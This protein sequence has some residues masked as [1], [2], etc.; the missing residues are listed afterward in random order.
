M[1]RKFISD[2]R[3]NMTVSGFFMV[4]SKDIRIAKNNNPYL[5]ITLM[6]KTGTIQA[7]IWDNVETFSE[8]FEKGDPVAVK[9]TITSFNNELQLKISSIRRVVPAQDKAYGYTLDDLIPS[10]QKDIGQM[11]QAIMDSIDRITN[12]FLQKLLRI[13]YTEHESILKTHPA[14][15]IL[16]HAF[17]GGLLEHT[18][19]MLNVAIG[20]CNTYPELD[21]ELVIS[22]VLLH[23]IG[24]IRELDSGLATDY[25]DCGNFIG[26]I[27]LGRDILLETIAKIDDFPEMLKLKLEHIILSHQGKLEWQ[28]PKE[29]SF[30]EALIVYFIDEMDTRLNQMT[31]EL[32]NDNAEGNWT[33][34]NNYFRRPLFK[35]SDS[36]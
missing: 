4:F 12:P 7:K 8:K 31:R 22:G 16:H 26:H 6:D 1:E 17:R 28:S 9:G 34:K 21:K 23:D 14:S 24:K 10:T 33:N 32:S 15:M 25:T 35:G 30:P 11:W 36:G 13:I 18:H 19:A 29:P 2:F 5:N 27:V 20:I 3:E